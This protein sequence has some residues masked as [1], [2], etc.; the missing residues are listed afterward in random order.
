MLSSKSQLVLG[1][2][3]ELN[4]VNKR[5]FGLVRSFT[6]KP[7]KMT[8]LEK[9]RCLRNVLGWSQEALSLRLNLSQRQYS[10][11]ETGK[12]KLT[13]RMYKEICDVWGVTRRE[14]EDLHLEELAEIVKERAILR[15]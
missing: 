12:S 2:N 1:R 9:I 5:G 3:Q 4:N 10:S 6:S 7:G 13:L 8:E 11:I 15:E 14:F